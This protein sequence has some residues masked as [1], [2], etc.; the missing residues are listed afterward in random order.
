[1]NAA[2]NYS[3]AYCILQTD[4]DYTGHGMVSHSI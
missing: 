2:G 1:M 3:S 4:S